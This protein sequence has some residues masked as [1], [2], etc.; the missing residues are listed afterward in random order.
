EYQRRNEISGSS[1]VCSWSKEFNTSDTYGV[2]AIVFDSENKNS[3]GISWNVI[4][5]NNSAPTASRSTPSSSSVSINIGTTQTFKINASDADG[6]LSYC[7][8][9]LDGEY[10]RRNEIS[11]SSSVCSWSKEFNT[12]DTY[13]VTAIVF[14]SENKNSNEISWNVI[15]NPVC[16]ITD[17]NFPTGI[18]ERGSNTQTTVTIKNTSTETRSFWVGLS[19]AHE[20]ATLDGW[21]KAWYDIKAKQTKILSPN[22]S[23]E[24]AFSFIIPE[25]LRPGQYFS[26]CKIWNNFNSGDWLMVEPIY[27][28]SLWHSEWDDN[29]LGALSFYLGSYD[30]PP[31]DIIGQLLWG[32]RYIAFG[33]KDLTDTYNGGQ[34]PL[35]YFNAN[36]AGNLSTAGTPLDISAGATFFIDL[37]DLL[38]LTPE[39]EEWVTMWID[40]DGSLGLGADLPAEIGGEMGITYHNFDYNERAI[41]DDRRAWGARLEASIPGFAITLVDYRSADEGL[42]KPSIHWTGSAGI[43]VN[44]SGN[45]NSIVSREVNIESLKSAFTEAFSNDRN[46]YQSIYSLSENL[47]SMSSEIFR[48]A[49]WDDGSWALTDG[50][51]A[52][53]LKL[54]KTW[55]IDDKCAHYFYLDVP[56][57]TDTLYVIT[58]G[59]T[60]NGDLRV[61][62]NEIPLTNPYYLSNNEGNEES[63][64]IENPE[65]GRWF[66]MIP[67]ITPYDGLNLVASTTS[68]QNIPYCISAYTN[69]INGGTVTGAG[70]YYSGETC[71]LVAIPN[72]GYIFDDWTENGTQVSINENY[73]FTVTSNRNLTANF[74]N[75]SSIFEIVD[76]LVLNIYPNPVY[77]KLFIEFSRPP[78]KYF[79]ILYN[80]IGQILLQ[81]QS[82]NIKEAFDLKDFSE[83]IFY[84]KI[85]NEEF[86]K[87]EKI[88]VQ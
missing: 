67:S 68:I 63:I 31:D 6:N 3:N 19:F 35:L 36:V 62:F 32:A 26:V 44:I 27:D 49:T 58:S 61:K 56:D 87:T 37:A 4:V 84:L 80:N 13:G 50:Q 70:N 15:V 47:Y 71:Y 53:D 24:L 38:K 59:G 46:L 65:E 78:K 51:W 42:Q 88:I 54:S 72:N 23:Q 85:F 60:P 34:K 14:D 10:Q 66:F 55:N 2:T 33:G 20:T 77:D 5:K 40:T 21:P 48:D 82:D 39:G 22:E 9:Y 79:I 86:I 12:S 8:W 57:N 64:I 74:V 76:D 11:G 29:E 25:N 69:P 81:K 45:V 52:T 17:F 73:D 7:E 30:T 18:Q 75:S 41:A 1:S 43:S 83:G 28:E 16:I